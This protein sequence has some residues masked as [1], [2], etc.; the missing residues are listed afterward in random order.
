MS[1]SSPNSM[2]PGCVIGV[3]Y[4]ERTMPS[5]SQVKFIGVSWFDLDKSLRVYG[6]NVC[7]TSERVQFTGIGDK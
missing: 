4:F 7:I 1:L 2:G 3:F 6:F 5:R